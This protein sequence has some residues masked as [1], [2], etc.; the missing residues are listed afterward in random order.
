M[1]TAP[2]LVLT[3]LRLSE[4]LTDWTDP[5]IAAFCLARIL[6][7]FESD[8]T[9]AT[10]TK[11]VFWTDNPLGAS[12]DQILHNLAE[13]GVLEFDE[14]RQQ[15]RWSAQFNWAELSVKTRSSEG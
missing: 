1:T 12:L 9:F 3:S 2:S 10:D 15:F 11:H 13:I 5:D 14:E 7:I 6:G 4:A 8:V